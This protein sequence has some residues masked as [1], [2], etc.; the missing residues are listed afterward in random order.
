MC[1]EHVAACPHL[2]DDNYYRLRRACG[3]IYMKVSD[4]Y[5]FFGN[6]NLHVCL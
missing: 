2:M 4:N 6:V 1:V 5:I 3:E